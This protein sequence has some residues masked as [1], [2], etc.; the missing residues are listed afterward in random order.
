MAKK[1]CEVGLAIDRTHLGQNQIEQ[2]DFIAITPCWCCYK[3]D[4]SVSDCPV[5]DTQHCLPAKTPMTSK[6]ESH[7]KQQRQPQQQQEQQQAVCPKEHKTKQQHQT[8]PLAPP[9]SPVRQ[10]KQA[11]LGQDISL[12]FY[13]Y[14]NSGVL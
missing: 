2:E 5:K 9:P 11:Q 4:H 1:A 8:Q 7:P 13:T 14:T 3:Y 12:R 6:Q 10:S